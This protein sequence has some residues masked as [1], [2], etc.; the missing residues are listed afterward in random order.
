MRVDSAAAILAATVSCGF[1][2]LLVLVLCSSLLTADFF[3]VEMAGKNQT[4]SLNDNATIFCKVLGSQHLNIDIMGNSWFRKHQV[5]ET[6]DKVFES[7]GKYQEAF[8]AGANVSLL[9]LKMGDA[10]LQLPRV[11]LED[12]GEYRCEVVITPEKAQ[13]TVIVIVVANPVGSLTQKKVMA[14][15]NEDKYILCKL[16]GFHPKD[17]NITWCQWTQEDPHCLEFSEGITTDPAIKNEDGTFNITSHLRMNHSVEHN[18]TYQCMIRHISLSTLMTLNI[19]LPG[20]EPEMETSLRTSSLWT[21]ILY[22]SVS[23]LILAI[24]VVSSYLS[25]LLWKRCRRQ[26]QSFDTTIY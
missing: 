19:T 21:T 2:W 8:R 5:N 20:K 3:T 16:S 1:S 26:K 4:V 9:R 7:I 24:I 11:Q 14:K 15:D 10:S 17:I 6:E 25:C 23:C 22:I 13:G 18:V 12:A